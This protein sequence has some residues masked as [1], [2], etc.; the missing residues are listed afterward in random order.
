MAAIYSSVFIEQVKLKLEIR[1]GE[2]KIKDKD[3]L[4]NEFDSSHDFSNLKKVC[5]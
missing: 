2:L 3:A 5:I 1:K 4:K